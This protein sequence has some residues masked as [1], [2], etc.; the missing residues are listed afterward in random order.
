MYPNLDC[1]NY[2]LQLGTN[3][4]SLIAPIQPAGSTVSDSVAEAASRPSN[5][6]A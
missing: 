3:A 1:L 6:E 2:E 5:N 4:T